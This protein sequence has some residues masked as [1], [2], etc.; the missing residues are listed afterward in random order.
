MGGTE[1]MRPDFMQWATSRGGMYLHDKQKPTLATWQPYQSDILRHIFPAGTGRLPYARVIWS[2]V[3][4]S[5]KTELAAAVQLY[6]GLFVDVPGEQYV[7]ANDFEGARGRVWRYIEGSLERNPLFA[8]KVTGKDDWRVVGNE[9]KLGN[10]TTIKAI[11]SDYKGEAGANLSLA[12]VDEPWGIMSEG[13][14]RLMTEFSPVPT[15]ENSMVFYTGYQGWEGQSEYWHNL[16]DSGRAEP[17]AELIHID[18]GD[19]NPACWRAGRTFVLWNHAARMPWH[20]EEYLAEQKRTLPP[21]EYLR[22]WENRRVR[23]ADAFCTQEQWD[24]LEDRALR[25]L[26]TGD[27]RVVVLGVDAAT[28]SDCSAV[29]AC[30]WDAEAR[31]VQEVF[32]RIWKPDGHEPLKLTETVGP[33]IIR[34]H[35]EQRVAGVYYD[36]Y[37]MAAIAE[38]C[39]S[40]GVNMIEFPQTSQ[41]VRSDTH[42][43]GLIWGG[44]LTHRGDPALA[45]HVLNA[46][47]KENERGR[48]IV[49]DIGSAKVD[50]AVALSMAALGAVEMLAGGESAVL[51]VGKNPFYG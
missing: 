31:R 49:K 40:A 15:R 27:Q 8:G 42:L 41:R 7:L 20:T 38:M 36:P 44:N 33:E 35:R 26:H 48:R 50:A 43:H 19:G 21:S 5:G 9:I 46:L 16:I 22:V 23:N 32:T 39:Q 3:K 1:K 25:G 11:A 18:D 45:A 47:T 29:V 30:G 12:T 34:L 14:A 28:K 51:R 2:D 4:K 17:V 37:Q 13:A 24:K 6:F 10:G